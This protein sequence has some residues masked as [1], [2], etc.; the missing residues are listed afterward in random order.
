MKFILVVFIN[1]FLIYATSAATFKEVVDLTVESKLDANVVQWSGASCILANKG[2]LI[3]GGPAQYET[4]FEVLTDINLG[5]HDGLQ[6]VKHEVES[7]VLK[8][9][10]DHATICAKLDNGKVKCFDMDSSGN[11]G[12]V[13]D[14]VLDRSIIGDNLWYVDFGTFY[15]NDAFGQP[16]SKAQLTH[17][18]KFLGNNYVA[19]FDGSYKCLHMKAG[20]YHL[21]ENKPD[22]VYPTQSS[23][24]LMKLYGSIGMFHPGCR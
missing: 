19:F 22:Y 18:V 10:D 15:P 5:S 1:L 4:D 13:I 17:S 21:L 12:V 23:D 3:C 7:I 9:V 2:R 20:A 24:L 6:T 16:Q 8:S 14:G 11:V